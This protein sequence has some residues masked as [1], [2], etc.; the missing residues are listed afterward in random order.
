MKCVLCGE[1]FETHKII[2]SWY[3]VGYKCSLKAGR[4]SGQVQDVKRPRKLTRT[5]KRSPA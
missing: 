1:K 4:L 5:T 3:G 2:R